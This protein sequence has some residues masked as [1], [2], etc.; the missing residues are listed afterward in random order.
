MIDDTNGLIKFAGMAVCMEA[1]RLTGVETSVVHELRYFHSPS[2]LACSRGA[3]ATSGQ[4]L[5]TPPA[6]AP[7]FMLEFE[8][9]RV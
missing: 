3:V 4:I 9:V 7:A 8:T 2:S 6:V 5:I 1:R